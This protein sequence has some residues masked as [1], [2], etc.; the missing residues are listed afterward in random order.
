[1]KTSRWIVFFLCLA[2]VS[3]GGNMSPTEPSARAVAP[4]AT[5]TP[6][7][8]SQPTATPLPHAYVTGFVTTVQPGTSVAGIPIRLIQGTYEAASTSGPTGS[9]TVDDGR[10]TAGPAKIVANPGQGCSNVIRNV[11]LPAGPLKLDIQICAEGAGPYP[12]SAPVPNP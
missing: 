3:C 11:Q 4:T 5:P 6:T 2:A 9:Y 7:P 8:L 10:I 12:T 1:M